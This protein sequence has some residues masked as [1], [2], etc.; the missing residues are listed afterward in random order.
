MDFEESIERMK[1]H[2]ESNKVKVINPQKVLVL[3]ESYDVLRTILEDYYDDVSVE[4][5]EG[6]LEV[7]S[8]VI[9]ISASAVTTFDAALLA[10]AVCK[11]DNI[12]IY[13]TTDGKI[14]CDI[15]FE[16]VYW[17]ATM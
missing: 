14:R 5:A 3:K 2:K 6:A 15:M 17:V 7:G 8:A 11:A 12:D 9:Q 1:K 10:E 13:P 4:I 16:D